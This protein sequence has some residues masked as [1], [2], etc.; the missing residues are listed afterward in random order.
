M[1]WYNPVVTPDSFW[2]VW[3]DTHNSQISL[4]Q[5]FSK[6]S[7]LLNGL[8]SLSVDI[9]CVSALVHWWSWFPSCISTRWLI[10]FSNEQVRRLDTDNDDRGVLKLHYTMSKKVKGTI[11]W[12]CCSGLWLMSGTS[13]LFY[14]SF[15]IYRRNMNVIIFTGLF[16]LKW[17]LIIYNILSMN[18][19]MNEWLWAE[20]SATWN[21]QAE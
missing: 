3:A 21:T 12:E 10:N 16:P 13:D 1:L 6:I 11:K 4:W 7:V 8:Q 14:L 15:S 2:P 17:H 19:N 5:A 9:I 18:E 20:L